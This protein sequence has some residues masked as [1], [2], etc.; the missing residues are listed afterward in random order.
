MT[1]DSCDHKKKYT[2]WTSADRDA[3]ALRRR[4]SAHAQPY[5][6]GCGGFHVG[7]AIG[8]CALGRHLKAQGMK[9]IEDREAKKEMA[10]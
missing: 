5:S 3:R 7:Q 2:T 9:R 4:K 6:C 1:E 8:P 10:W